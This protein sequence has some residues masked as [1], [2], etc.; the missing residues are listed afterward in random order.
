[1]RLP[2]VVR[3]AAVPDPDPGPEQFGEP[4]V[5]PVSGWVWDGEAIEFERVVPP[6]GNLWVSGRQFWLGTGL[7]GVNITFW[8]DSQVVHLLNAGVRIKS[9]RSHFSTADLTVLAARGA[10]KA[11][12]SPLPPVEE[13]TAI[14]VERTVNRSGLVGLA[15]QAVLAAEILNGRRVGIRIDGNTLM[16]FDPDTR[17]LLRSRSNPLT[18][19]QAR[20]LRGARP[21][22]PPPHTTAAPITVQRRASDNGRI[23]ITGQVLSLGRLHAR[24][25]VTAHVTDT[26]ITV[27]L[28]DDRRTFR[29]T[30]D[31]PVRSIK[32]HRPRKAVP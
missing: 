12:P 4:A 23:M 3:L 24:T 8:A 6:S 27:E 18:Y 29:R 9:V 10:R 26:V 20:R 21:A 11:G 28:G 31:Q 15:G 5:E 16:F 19:E 1:L 22:G 7:A 32:A 2:S 13:G 25:V 14:E 17:E 30:T